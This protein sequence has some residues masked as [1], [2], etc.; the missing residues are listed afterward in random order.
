MKNPNNAICFTWRIP[1]L[2]G[3]QL[4][5]TQAQL[6]VIGVAGKKIIWELRGKTA[7]ESELKPT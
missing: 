1:I 2:E 4:L 7:K 3:I 6:K 5:E